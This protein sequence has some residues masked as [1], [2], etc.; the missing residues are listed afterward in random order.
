[1]KKIYFVFFCLVISSMALFG[2]NRGGILGEAIEST[3]KLLDKAKEKLGENKAKE[4]LGEI[5]KSEEYNECYKNIEQ[6]LNNMPGK[7]SSKKKIRE[8]E[9]ALGDLDKLNNN[10]HF[11]S[12]FE[13]TDFKIQ[14]LLLRAACKESKLK[15][16]LKKVSRLKIR[17]IR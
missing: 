9:K 8:I 4:K 14:N 1:M 12:D 6:N 3:H 10:I 2:V 17:K 16:R 7:L 11:M 5:N 15:K 13:K